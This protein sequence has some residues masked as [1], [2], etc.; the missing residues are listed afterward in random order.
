MGKSGVPRC[1]GFEG[2]PCTFGIEK[3]P[4]SYRGRLYCMFHLPLEAEEKPEAGTVL[5]LFE[6]YLPPARD[7]SGAQLPGPGMYKLPNAEGA[8]AWNLRGV[9]IGHGVALEAGGTKYDFSAARFEGDVVFHVHNQVR[10]VLDRATFKGILTVSAGQNDQTQ[11]VSA[12][13]ACFR[14]T[15]D[16]G[17]ARISRAVFDDAR[18]EAPLK[19]KAERV[20]SDTSFYRARFAPGATPAESEADY[21]ALRERFK[22]HGARDWEG[23]F[24]ALEKRCQRR[25]LKPW[26]VE[27][28]VSALYDWVSGYGS[29]W[30]RAGL[31]FIGLQVVALV[32]YAR[33]L[34][35]IDV[36][37]ASFTAAQIFKPFELF[38]AKPIGGPLMPVPRTPGLLFGTAAHS[39]ASFA[40]LG[41]FLLALRW[42]FKRE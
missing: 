41:L 16:F 27:R 22:S 19:L 12:R 8:P 36:D 40:L 3:A 11:L 29:D 30:A 38:G 6:R 15:A 20:S 25:A 37:L 10:L 24:Y 13:G 4:F 42:R 1:A 21:R 7:L 23:L 18:F 14:K 5:A 28:W 39:I 31:A 32:A 9:R 34:S 35:G 26:S 17:L 33:A 2:R